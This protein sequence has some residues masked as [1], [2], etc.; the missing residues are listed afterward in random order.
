[1]GAVKGGGIVINVVMD[2][3]LVRVGSDDKLV[4]SL[5]PPHSQLIADTVGILRRN[6]SGQEGLAYLVAKHISVGCLLPASGGFV[7]AFP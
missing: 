1:M 3:S 4:F 5:R 6:L 2:M 7:P